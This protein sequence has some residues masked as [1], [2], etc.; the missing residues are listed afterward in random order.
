[1]TLYE[2]LQQSLL[3]IG[4]VRPAQVL[5]PT[6]SG[7][8]KDALNILVDSWNADG[9]MIVAPTS[10]SFTLVS[11]TASYTWGTGGTLNSAR[12]NRLLRSFIRESDVDYPVEIIEGDQF[13][14]IP[15][16]TD[17]GRPQYIWCN[18]A[19]PLAAVKFYYVPDS[20]Y[21]WHVDSEK[22]LIDFSTLTTAIALPGHYLEAL[23]W[24]LAIRLCSHY[25]KE[26]SP[27]LMKMADD[28]KTVVERINAVSK[29]EPVD[30]GLFTASSS[31]N[32]KNILT[33][34]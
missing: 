19:Y 6:Q 16:K 9:L 31:S 32:R 26:V 13:Q 7:T 11:G 15:S 27:F 18:F 34:P 23:K 17:T 1:M 22:D 10:E 30:L 3:S 25:N 8:A 20:N 5:S 4:V 21:A 14:A 33:G 12:P 28:S 29:N 24:N 2:L